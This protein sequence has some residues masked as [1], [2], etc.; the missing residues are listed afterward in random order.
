MSSLN[1]SKQI[2]KSNWRNPVALQ[3]SMLNLLNKR[4]KWGSIGVAQKEQSEGDGV[5]V[6]KPQPY[7]EPMDRTQEVC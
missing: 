3:N 6:A 4:W 1:I 7:R 5:A 2:P